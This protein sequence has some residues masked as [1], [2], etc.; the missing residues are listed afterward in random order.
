MKVANMAKIIN[1]GKYYIKYLPDK[2]WLVV[3]DKISVADF[4]LLR[5][6]IN[7]NKKIRKRIDDIIVE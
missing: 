5:K 2:K 4:V 6:V 1:W 3:K 7:K